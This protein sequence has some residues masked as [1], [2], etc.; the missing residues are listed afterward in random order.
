MR[1]LKDLLPRKRSS[2]VVVE[3]DEK[4]IFHIAKRILIE[5]YGVRGGENI[6]PSF[7][8]EKKLFL[9]PRSSLWANEVYLM[10]EHITR[11]INEMS[12]NEVVKEIKITQ[13]I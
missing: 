8:K 7:Y 5:E 3:I 10:K 4:T 6:I 12:G 9:S 1:N 2:S 13:Q 11:R